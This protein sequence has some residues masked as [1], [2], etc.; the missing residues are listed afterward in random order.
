MGHVIILKV[1]LGV[2]TLIKQENGSCGPGRENER[3]GEWNY[4]AGWLHKSCISC[5][6]ACQKNSTPVDHRS[7]NCTWTHRDGGGRR[8]VVCVSLDLWVCVY[9]VGVCAMASMFSL[10]GPGFR[11]RSEMIKESYGNACCSLLLHIL[12]EPPTEAHRGFIYHCN[13]PVYLP[14]M[15]LV[16]KRGAI[17]QIRTIWLSFG[18]AIYFN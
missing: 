7:C 11:D 6:I 3:K 1:S 9:L 16:V 5:F 18:F 2:C 13:Y 17:H 8:V 12:G 4:R 10:E 15:V 14:Y